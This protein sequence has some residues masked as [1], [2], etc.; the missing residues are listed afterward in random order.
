[1]EESADDEVLASVL[2]TCQLEAR[3]V[4][5]PT[6]CGHYEVAE[7]QHRFGAA[8]FHLVDRGVCEVRSPALGQ[9]VRLAAGDLLVLPRGT[10]HTISSGAGVATEPYSTL[11]CGEFSFRTG[12]N[13]LLRS[14]PDLIVVRSS[15]A[16]SGLRRVAEM[17]VEESHS[18]RFGRRA[19]IDQLADALFVMM[20]R[21]HIEH[22]P[23][24]RGLLAALA[25]PRLGRV[26]R[27]MHGDPGRYWTVASLAAVALLSRTTFSERFTAL[28]DES[29]YQYLT[30]WRM[31][32]ALSR[33]RDPRLS[34]AKVAE[35]LGYQTESAFRRSFKRVHGFGPGRVRREGR[36]PTG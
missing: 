30:R 34:V 27:A 7:P 14:L 16:G 20:L 15:E 25:D 17:M 32:E 28:L 35:Q 8:W 3:L 11:L 22:S 13:A 6:F 9:S 33:L 29:P 31:T 23:M 19:V 4:H 36:Q 26:L 10:A 5:N 1:M 2:A 21:H 12:D 18:S 24:R